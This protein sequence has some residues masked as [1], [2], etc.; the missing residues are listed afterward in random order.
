MSI[1]RI[2]ILYEK[3]VADI[4]NDWSDEQELVPIHE[5]PSKN[6]IL[7]LMHHNENE[8]VRLII[9]LSSNKYYAWDADSLLHNGVANELELPHNK[10]LKLIMYKSSDLEGYFCLEDTELNSIK[11]VYGDIPTFKLIPKLYR[12]P[13]FRKF[14]IEY[15]WLN[16]GKLNLINLNT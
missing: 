14:P 15:I 7:K 16:N 1:K 10:S 3:I 5:N 11:E 8:T 6:D 2:K 9:D 4:P 12:L 13:F